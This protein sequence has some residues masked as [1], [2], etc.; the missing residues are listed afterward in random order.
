MNRFYSKKVVEATDGL[1]KGR[2]NP[3][4]NPNPNPIFCASFCEIFPPKWSKNDIKIP[5]KVKKNVG[6]QTM[7]IIHR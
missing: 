4:P 5:S 7:H 6:I 2:P 3:N 1:Q